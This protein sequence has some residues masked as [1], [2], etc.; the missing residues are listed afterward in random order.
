MLGCPGKRSGMQ[1]CKGVALMEAQLR[2]GVAEGRIGHS[3][4]IQKREQHL[5]ASKGS[6]GALVVPTCSMRSGFERRSQNRADARCSTDKVLRMLRDGDGLSKVT[7]VI[8]AVGFLGSHPRM[9]E[10]I[11]GLAGGNPSSTCPA[12]ES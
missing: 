10:C 9:S 4:L 5:G 2:L 7:A 1:V 11:A 6:P 8:V 12:T 3:I